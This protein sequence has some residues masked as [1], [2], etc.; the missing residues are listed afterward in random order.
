MVERAGYSRAQGRPS[1]TTGPSIALDAP[2][3]NKA[4][5]CRRRLL[6]WYDR[7]G[8]QFPWRSSNA[9]L[10]QQ[11]VAEV[12]LQ[13]TQASTVSHFFDSF[14]QEFRGWDDIDAAPIE[15]LENVLRPI[16]LWR[17]RAT[18]LK[19]LAREMVGRA[20]SF[21]SS[22][23]EL[24]SLPAVGQYV[25]SAVLLF[26]YKRAEPPARWKHGARH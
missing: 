1:S 10:Y 20:G 13:R 24:E 4:R 12:L 11:V 7:H 2:T 15:Q 21:P 18:S 9:G 22:R 14:F 6:A 19:A 26:A 8:R 17:R 23:D 3:L 16:G 25:A 5:W